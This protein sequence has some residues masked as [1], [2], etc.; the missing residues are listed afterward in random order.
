MDRMT[1]TTERG[2]GI[3]A[4]NST[5]N[6]YCP[7]IDQSMEPTAQHIRTRDVGTSYDT[8]FE[9]RLC[10]NISSS[11]QN[12][13]DPF[14]IGISNSRRSMTQDSTMFANGS[15]NGELWPRL[16]GT[17]ATSD[18]ESVHQFSS[19]S[20][21]VADGRQAAAIKEESNFHVVKEQLQS[22]VKSHLKRLSRDIDLGK[23]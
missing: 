13:G 20:N 14:S 3:A 4:T 19:R 17:T 6:L 12:E 1:S 9:E 23:T 15:V 21:I 5:S 18:Y 8:L 10:N 11:I 7:Q 16:S 22:M 2:D